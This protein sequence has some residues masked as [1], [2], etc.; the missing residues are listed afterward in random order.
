MILGKF[1]VSG[2]S[3]EPYLKEGDQVIAFRFSGIKKGDIVV[4]K[5]KSK[6]MIKRITRISQDSIHVQGDNKNDSLE[7]NPI[8]K[9]DI[10]GKVILK[11]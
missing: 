8:N 3:M 11:I 1:K 2:H 9:K 6:T 10:I 5:H 4:F 7:I